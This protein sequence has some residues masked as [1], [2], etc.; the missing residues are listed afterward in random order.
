MKKKMMLLLLCA[1]TAVAV[2]SFADITPGAK[3]PADS[4]ISQMRNELNQLKAK[5]ELL[6]FRTKSLEFTVQQLKQPP[7]PVP[8]S[9]P[10][11]NSLWQPP[12]SDSATPKIWG[13][14]EVNGWTF[15]LV[16]CERAY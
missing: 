3:L 9:P 13:E 7:H 5:V 2:V 1:A 11:G 15:Y 12:P 16:P 14:K 10:Q 6:E 8:L 4:E